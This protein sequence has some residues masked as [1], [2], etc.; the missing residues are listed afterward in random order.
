MIWGRSHLISTCGCSCLER[1]CV[2][3]VSND[4]NANV[5]ARPLAWSGEYR[6]LA[7]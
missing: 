3:D 6:D 4:W 2:L 1:L 5:Y 7:A